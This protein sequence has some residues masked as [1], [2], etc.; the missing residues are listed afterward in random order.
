MSHY[1]IRHRA[2]TRRKFR[3]KI[4]TYTGDFILSDACSWPT[5]FLP[6]RYC[7]TRRYHTVLYNAMLCISLIAYIVNLPMFCHITLQALKIAH[8]YHITNRPSCPR[9]CQNRS[10]SFRYPS[11]IHFLRS[12]H[13]YSS[14]LSWPPVCILC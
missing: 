8:C 4:G 10:R 9:H 7:R 11:E 5:I 6:P 2:I 12:H 1:P 14:S 13:P 3:A